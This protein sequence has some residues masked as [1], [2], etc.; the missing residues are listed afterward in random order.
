MRNRLATVCS[1]LLSQVLDVDDPSTWLIRRLE[2]DLQ[3]DVGT[4]DEDLLARDWGQPIARTVART[5]TRGAD[6]DTVLH[7]TDRAAYLTQFIADLAEGRAW[8]KWYYNPFESLRSLLT[9]SAIREALIR[10]PEQAETVLLRLATQGCLER[11]LTVLSTD[12]AQRVYETC[13]PAAGSGGRDPKLIEVLL[14]VWPK[15][16]LCVSAPSV[17]TAH[18]SLRLYLAAR[19]RSAGLPADGLRTA[20]DHLLGLAEIL[21]HVAEPNALI[22]RLTTGDLH[23]AIQLARSVGLTMHLETLPFFR[24]IAAGDGDWIARVA[25]TVSP[26]TAARAGIKDK[27]RAT[28][29]TLSTPF[30]GIFLLLPSLIDLDLPDLI[31]AAAYAHPQGMGKAQV[32]HYLL[33]L[34]CLGQP[35]A[36]EAVHDP[37][38]HLAAGL[39]EP[40]SIETLQRLSES[41]TMVMDQTGLRLLVERVAR[42]GRAEGRCLCAELVT[43]E[44][45][46]HEVLLLRDMTRD[47]W[48]YTACV[49]DEAVEIEAALDQ[50]LTVIRETVEAP[51]ECLLLGP[52]LARC[53]DVE[54]L[55][56]NEVQI[57]WMDADN[58][59]GRA[60]LDLGQ[61]CDGRPMI[62]W[63]AEPDV[64]PGELR[65]TLARY[66]TRA[67][68]AAQELA[69]L[70]L[71]NLTPPVTTYSHFDLT[72]SLVAHAVLK[73]F[74]SR[75]M[76]FEWSSAEFLYHNFLAGTSTLRIDGERIDVEL[77]RSPLHVI[78]RMAG[79]DGQTYTVPWLSNAQVTL[80]LAAG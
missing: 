8:G 67:K 41:A 43:A 24:Q 51:L 40:P 9:S 19:A 26:T 18:N 55:V 22:A 15:A 63:T 69:Y 10:E 46:S 65:A 6:G 39:D 56:G 59:Q 71:A 5:L 23:G 32:L 62:V 80:S 66:L 78:L 20:V 48:V 12:D 47:A 27:T 14:G 1:R 79:V 4:V 13:I 44:S 38:L 77:P 33:S 60:P 72:W 25:R 68:P 31:E 42:R 35:R 2:V 45:S 57:V 70:S 49:S 30:G 21:R 37:A 11:V 61:S 34:R 73:A 75:L 16:S 74:A 29:R 17:A 76:G 36:I 53:L 3:A 58:A 28:T 7:F 52:S 64:L 54:A 50:G